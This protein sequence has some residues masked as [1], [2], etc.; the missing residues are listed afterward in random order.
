MSNKERSEPLEGE[1]AT[2]KLKRLTR[3]HLKDLSESMNKLCDAEQLE[4]LAKLGIVDTGFY[5]GNEY[6][7]PLVTHLVDC[8]RNFIPE[9]PNDPNSTV[10]PDDLQ[11]NVGHGSLCVCHVG[12]IY[13]RLRLC[14]AKV[15]KDGTLDKKG[16]GRVAQ[17]RNG[18]LIYFSHLYIENTNAWVCFVGHHVACR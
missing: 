12:R 18:A 7:A 16:A 2:R 15:S 5:K 9:D 4:I 17:V 8:C 13:Q 1:D 14:I 3:K 6:I 11:D 10:D